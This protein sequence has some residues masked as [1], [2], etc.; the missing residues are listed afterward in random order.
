[1]ALSGYS[2]ASVVGLN[3]RAWTQSL[4]CE[5]TRSALSARMAVDDVAAGQRGERA[6]ARGAAQE[7]PPRRVGQE[8]CR[9]LDQKLRI[10]AGNLFALT[11][12]RLLLNHRPTIMARR[13]FGTISASATWTVKKSHDRRHGEEMDVA[14]EVVAAEERGEVLELHRLPD[15][16]ARQHDDDAGER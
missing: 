6:E 8:L 13:L 12:H 5:T 9:V 16:K 10:D 14:G 1:M 2:G 4:K 7:Q 11:G 15:R 3:S